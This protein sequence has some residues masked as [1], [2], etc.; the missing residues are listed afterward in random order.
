M[1]FH[2]YRD[3]DVT[4]QSIFSMHCVSDGARSKIDDRHDEKASVNP[5]SNILQC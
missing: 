5:Q 3:V 1:S 4:G 2:A